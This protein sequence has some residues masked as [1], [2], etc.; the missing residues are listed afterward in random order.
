MERTNETDRR[1]EKRKHSE[2]Y[3]CPACG[4]PVAES[5]P[6]VCRMLYGRDAR[7]CRRCYAVYGG[8]KDLQGRLPSGMGHEREDRSLLL[9]A[10][11]I[12]TPVH[13]HYDHRGQCSGA[14]P[15]VGLSGQVAQDRV[16]HQGRPGPRETWPGK[17]KNN[18][19]ITYRIAADARPTPEPGG[20]ADKP[21]IETAPHGERRMT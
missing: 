7:T 19:P 14:R 15:R 6:S 2:D 1:I 5:D 20:L 21:G 11:G 9:H 17:R 3:A 10:G 18:H 4:T 8:R 13:L 16:D 12:D